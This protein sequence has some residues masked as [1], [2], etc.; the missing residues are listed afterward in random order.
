[1]LLECPTLCLSSLGKIFC[2][3]NNAL[4]WYQ[5]F[6]VKA[7]LYLDLRICWGLIYLSFA[8]LV[9]LSQLWIIRIFNRVPMMKIKLFGDQLMLNK[10]GQLKL[11]DHCN[12]ISI[13][14][15]RPS[16]TGFNS[17]HSWDIFW[18]KNVSVAEVNQ[19]HCLE[20]SGQCLENV[21]RTHLRLAS[22][23]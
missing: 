3:D 11:K 21:D 23:K 8:G 10:K 1:M 17:Q 20:E 15:S 12:M 5:S 6:I 7:T 16:C 19:R 18:W 13:L 9:S 22:G 14:A 4:E 2:V